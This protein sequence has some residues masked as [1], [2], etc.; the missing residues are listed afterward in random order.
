[1]KLAVLMSTVGLVVGAAVCAGLTPAQ[2]GEPVAYTQRPRVLAVTYDPILRTQGDQRLHAYKGWMDPGAMLTRELDFFADASHDIVQFR[3]T[4]HIL[5]DMWPVKADGFRYTEAQYLAGAWHSPDGVDYRTVIRDFDLARKCDTGELDEVVLNGAP[6]FGYWES[7]MVGKGAYWCNSSGLKRS[8]NARKFII[9]GWNYERPDMIGHAYGHRAESIMTEVYDGWS[10][11][12]DRTVWDRFGWNI[13]QTTISSIYGIG[14]CHYPCNGDS[15]YDYSNPQ[16]VTSYAPDWLNN[17]PNLIGDTA[18]VNR[19]TWGTEPYGY[20]GNYMLWWYHHMPHVDGRNTLDG[21]DRLNNWW[22]YI[23]DLNRWPES[24]GDMIG[25]SL[26]PAPPPGPPSTRVTTNDRDDFRPKLNASGRVVWSGYDGSDFEIYSANADGSDLV[27]ITSNSSIDE[28]P[29]INAA[30]RIVWQSFDGAQYDI[31]CADSD[32]TDVVRITN[33]D[34]MDWHPQINDSGRIVWDGFDGDDL[35]IFS[36]NSDGTDVVQI[37]NNTAASGMP[38]DDTWP[39]INNA[40]RVVWMGCDSDDWEIFSANADG[41]DLVQLSASSLDDEYPQ[42]NDLGRVVWHCYWSSFNFSSAADIYSSNADGS[43]YVRITN[44]SSEDWHP[45]INN[46]NVVVWMRYDGSDWEIYAANA[47]GTG[48]TNLTSNSAQDMHPVIDDDGIVAWQGLDKNPAPNDQNPDDD[49]EIF[50]YKNGTVYQITDNL[51]DDRAPAIS[52]GSGF[53]WHGDAGAQGEADIFTA[54]SSVAGDVDG[55]FVVNGLDLTAVLAAWNTA[56]G[57]PLWNPAAD[58][59]GNDIING[60]DLTAVMSNWTT[61]SAAA[62]DSTAT[63]ATTST[64]ETA[65]PG[66]R[67][68]R[69]GN[70]K[71][72]KGNAQGK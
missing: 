15:D 47:D 56:P 36:A 16:T 29:Q 35:E 34:T 9:M 58:L 45:Q 22:G 12:G 50:A 27:Q 2:A 20:P 23:Q 28:A 32:G 38:T 55:N 1:V 6:Y 68:S 72:S 62:A 19:D 25:V 4:A 40:G 54:P 64:T 31:Y 48:I 66:P 8:A 61:A 24:K 13:G 26:S 46:S 39:Q 69:P 43:D 41:T 3:V 33:N 18:Q 11:N 42:I 44:T 57:D 5:A 7:H 60:L 14:S 21:Y 30:G 65:K 51:T 71:R 70:V 49:W 37:T 52:T 67:G 10:T 53:A 63:E 59:D 17:F